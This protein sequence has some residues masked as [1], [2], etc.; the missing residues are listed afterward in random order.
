MPMRYALSTG[1]PI[2]V[3]QATT[4]M[5]DES[6]QTY[7]LHIDTLL[8][9]ALGTNAYYGVFTANIHSDSSSSQPMSDAIVSS[10]KTRGVA[11]VSAK[12]MLDW[13]DG[14]NG[15]TFS[16]IAWAGN[17]LSFSVLAGRGATGLQALVPVQ[18]G[19]LHLTGITLNSA[20][21]T[22]TVQTIKGVSYAFVAAAAGQYR[23][24]YA[25]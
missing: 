25:F 20:P 10:A 3:Y 14:R 18:V 1:A 11:V 16:G 8:D 17:T 5:T 24:S 2:D 7:P 19:T 12:Q 22:Y 15:S 13:L 23:A 6:G 9:N 4:Q 21:V